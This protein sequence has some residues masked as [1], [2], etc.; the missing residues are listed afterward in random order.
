MVN[1]PLPADRYLAPACMVAIGTHDMV[2]NVWEYFADVVS[3][4]AIASKQLPKAGYG[5]SI[6]VDGLPLVTTDMSHALYKMIISGRP[7]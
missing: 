5:S 7:R 6:H 1:L 3:D 4:S 2:G